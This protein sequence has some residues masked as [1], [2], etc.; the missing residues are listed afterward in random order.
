M[1]KDKDFKASIDKWVA[2]TEDKIMA[3]VKNSIEDLVEDANKPVKAGGRM[4][5]DTGFLRASSASAINHLPEGETRG[6]HRKKNENGVIYP[7]D[8]SV[9]LL[10]VLPKFKMGDVFYFGWTAEYANKMNIK[11]GFL[12]SACQKWADFINNNVRRLKE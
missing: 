9:S 8:S 1:S 2:D 7:Y 12:D 5:V 4:P 11:Y 6:R 3:V 10:G